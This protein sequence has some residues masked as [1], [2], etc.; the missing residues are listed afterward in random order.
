MNKLYINKNSTTDEIANRIAAKCS[1]SHYGLM[2]ISINDKIE[3]SLIE[4][5]CRN[6]FTFIRYGMCIQQLSLE[7]VANTIHKFIRIA[8]PCR[9][10]ME[11]AYAIKLGLNIISPKEYAEMYLQKNDISPEISSMSDLFEQN[12]QG[13]YMDNLNY[14]VHKS[15]TEHLCIIADE[16][17][18]FIAVI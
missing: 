13:Y 14:A 11:I 9:Y 3:F 1:E 4:L 6:V 7:Q 5:N 15:G 18:A 12:V 8:T 16:T 2:Q 10:N 17:N